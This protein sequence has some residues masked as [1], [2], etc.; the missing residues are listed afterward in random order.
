LR[1]K[2]AQGGCDSGPDSNDFVFDGWAEQRDPKFA[3]NK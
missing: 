1:V 2:R 3:A